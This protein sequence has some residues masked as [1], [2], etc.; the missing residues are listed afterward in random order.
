MVVLG[1]VSRLLSGGLQRECRKVIANVV[2]NASK[3]IGDRRRMLRKLRS[4]LVAALLCTLPHGTGAQALLPRAF[5]GAYYF[6]GWAGAPTSQH[7]RGLLNGPY[8]GREPLTGWR[9]DRPSVLDRELEQA[10]RFG[11]AFFAFDWYYNAAKSP[12][13]TLN[14]ALEEYRSLPA[15]HGVKYAIL[16]VDNDRWEVPP[17]AWQ[18][19]VN[20]WVMRDFTAPDYVR[21]NGEP[22]L[23][24]L[25]VQSLQQAFGSAA[26][27]NRALAMLRATA[28]AHGLPGVFVLAGAQISGYYPHVGSQFVQGA[29][30]DGLTSYGYGYVFAQAPLRGRPPSAPGPHP[31]RQL[32]QT[33]A[34]VWSL[35]ARSSPIHYVPVVMGGW[36]PRPWGERLGGS[37]LWFRRTPSAFESWTKAA[38]DWADAHPYL[39]VMVEG[40]PLVLICSWN[41]LGEGSYV[42]PTAGDGN[43]YGLAL[44]RALLRP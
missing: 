5:V 26:G 7:F 27:V 1:M 36:D 13:P 19:V 30:Y 18:T 17:S 22:L 11:I 23:I 8:S 32:R 15:H 43:T 25:D 24:I 29:A 33:A 2:R 4:T 3:P 6:D 9:D 38:I 20:H 41:E 10:H 16:Y 28:R 12:F 42:I 21:I 44:R 34:S 40:R 14:T 31:F 39:N 35:A 37:L